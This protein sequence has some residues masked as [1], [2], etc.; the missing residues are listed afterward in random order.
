MCECLR[1]VG[2]MYSS[3]YGD[4]GKKAGALVKA[5]V[6]VEVAKPVKDGTEIRRA[7]HRRGFLAEMK[8]CPMCGKELEPQRTKVF[9][10]YV[11]W[12]LEEDSE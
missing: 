5:T 3:V 2:E 8:F 10:T 6:S 12:N 9:T 11:N 7:K 4:Y 1:K